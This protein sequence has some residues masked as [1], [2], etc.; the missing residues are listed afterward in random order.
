MFGTSMRTRRV[1]PSC[2]TE[3][4]TWVRVAS[5]GWSK[6]AMR[7]E[8]FMPCRTAATA[9]AG[10]SAW[11]S[12]LRL[13]TTVNA[14][15]PGESISPGWMR[16]WA[17]SPAKGEVMRDFLRRLLASPRLLSAARAMAMAALKLVSACWADWRVTL[18][19]SSRLWARSL[20]R[21]ACWAWAWVWA[22]WAS[23]ACTDRRRSSSS[24]A[25][26]TAPAPTRSPSCTM[27]RVTRPETSALSSARF[28]ARRVPVKAM[29]PRK[30]WFS[31][32]VRVTGTRPS[33]L[34]ARWRAISARLRYW[35]TVMVPAMRTA[36][37]TA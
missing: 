28:T 22:S 5:K 2:M 25:E 26:S 19:F 10:R 29:A 20:S 33:C 27:T 32:A 17:T 16:R 18:R 23:A 31:T 4:L 15:W 24:W 8:A 13:S 12:S 6:P 9:S 11:I 37:R 7:K 36:E 35:W 21:L 14:V 3:P 30:G 34:V 1:R